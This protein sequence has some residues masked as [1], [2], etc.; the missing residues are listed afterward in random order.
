MLNRLFLVTFCRFAMWTYKKRNTTRT[1][2]EN[3]R[4]SLAMETTTKRSN[5]TMRLEYR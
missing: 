5:E 4:A 3:A 1:I 2:L